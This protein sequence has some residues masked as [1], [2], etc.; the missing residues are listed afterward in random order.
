M[1]TVLAMCKSCSCNW[2]VHAVLAN[3][4]QGHQSVFNNL[5]PI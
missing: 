4:S 1:V 3:S 5:G 2:T